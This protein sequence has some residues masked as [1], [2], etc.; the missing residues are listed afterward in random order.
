MSTEQPAILERPRA[1][2]VATVL[3]WVQGELTILAGALVL[4]LLARGNG[5]LIQGTLFVVGFVTIGVGLL[6]VLAAGGL[7]SA[8]RGARL[9]TTVWMAISALVGALSVLLQ[10]YVSVVPVVA[11]I[12]I[13]CLLWLG[14]AR[15]YFRSGRKRPLPG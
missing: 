15:A 10:A 14:R 13:V 3:S 7:L 5:S 1:V 8:R 9:A 2:T 11:A 6:P 4:F 12:L